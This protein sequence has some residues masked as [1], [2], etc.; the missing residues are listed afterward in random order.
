[1]SDIEVCQGDCPIERTLNLIGGKW[2]TVILWH[3]GIDGILRY[4]ELKRRMPKITERMFS[5]QL[6]ELHTAG[7][8]DRVEYPQVPPKVEY[9][10][11]EKGQSLMPLLN[12]LCEW[13]KNNT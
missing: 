4:G 3:L 5:R 6:K 10:L 2:K 13:G 8:I 1:M 11:T 9:L 12:I 7:L